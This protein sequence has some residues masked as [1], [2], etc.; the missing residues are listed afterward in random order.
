MEPYTIDEKDL[1]TLINGNIA[2]KNLMDKISRGLNKAGIYY[3]IF[4]RIKTPQSIANKLIKKN[5]KYKSRQKG[6]QDIIGVRV[7]L[8]YYDDIPVC[9][10]ILSNMFRVIPEDSEEDIPKAEEFSPIRRNYVFWLP[11]EIIEMFPECLWKNYR[12]EK[13]FELQ[14]RT[15]FSEGWYEVEHDI[16]YK[17][18]EE[19][20]GEEYYEYHRGLNSINATLEICD[21]EIVRNLDDLAYDCYKRGQIQQMLRYKLRIHLDSEEISDEILNII[22]NTDGFLKSMYKVNREELLCCISH[23]EMTGLPRTLENIIFVYNKLYL[24]NE[25]IEKLESPLLSRKLDKGLN[26]FKDIK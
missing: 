8:Y 7:V 26:G 16:R 9:K 17:H 10:K 22:K 15:I 24:N 11:E 20:I 21:H 25:K 18:K 12:I 1:V 14:L 19:W 4:A 6:M 23:P 3:R 2:D 5:E 13:T